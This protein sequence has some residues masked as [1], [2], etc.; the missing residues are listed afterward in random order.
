VSTAPKIHLDIP[1]APG[2]EP[3][4]GD[5]VFVERHHPRC[6]G[7]DDC[8]LSIGDD[9]IETR[10]WRVGTVIEGDEGDGLEQIELRYIGDDT[11]VARRI[12]GHRDGDEGLWTLGARCW[13]EVEPATQWETAGP[14]DHLRP[15][16][17]HTLVPIEVPGPPAATSL[18]YMIATKHD[19]ERRDRLAGALARHGAADL[20]ERIAD[21]ARAHG[22]LCARE[23]HAHTSD[24]WRLFRRL[25]AELARMAGAPPSRGR[26]VVF[27]EAAREIVDG[28]TVARLAAAGVQ[29]VT[30]AEMA[31]L[32]EERAARERA[33]QELAHARKAI[34]AQRVA[35]QQMLV[36]VEAAESAEAAE[37]ELEQLR[38]ALDGVRLPT[39]TQ[40]D[41]EVATHVEH[42]TDAQVIE[43]LIDGY[44]P[45]ADADMD[46]LR[47]E[48][49]RLRA[50]R[51]VVA[52][53]DA[54]V[55]VA[56]AQHGE[57]ERLR[58]EVARLTE[59][60]SFWELSAEPARRRAREEKSDG[61]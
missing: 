8:T 16:D 24:A 48:V 5:A 44:R 28:D 35:A 19:A 18:E 29:L 17:R 51:V 42:E 2:A 47:A 14:N 56:T 46:A 27:P 49:D 26:E 55:D 15:D 34:E 9:A 37:A 4:A 61:R 40:Y 12:G 11:L 1:D 30:S 10:G 60:V 54:L 31:G 3:S 50:E 41:G 21:A 32:R 33:E 43:R 57:V 13:C 22:G 7:P 58:A 52:G 23:G 59:R 39:E 38:R 6:P 45:T 36:R 53:A 20:R 25:L